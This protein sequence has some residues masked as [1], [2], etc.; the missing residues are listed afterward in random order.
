MQNMEAQLAQQG[1]NLEMYCQFMQPTKEALR[2]ENRGNA[3]ASVKVQAAIELIVD[4]ENLEATE[5]EMG[6]AMAVIARQNR[7]TVE[8]LKQYVDAEFTAAVRR[9]VLTSKVMQLIREAAVIE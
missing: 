4:L 7:L 9:S 6:E 1:L 2:E 5:T 3:V 8:Q